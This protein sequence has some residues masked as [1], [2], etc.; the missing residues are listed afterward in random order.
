MLQAI[1]TRVNHGIGSL[2][3]AD[4]FT[5]GPAIP[6]HLVSSLGSPTREDFHLVARVAEHG[7]QGAS[8]EAASS[9]DEYVQ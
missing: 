7:G 9:S 1:S 8:E 4:P 5:S 3:L 6:A 2:K